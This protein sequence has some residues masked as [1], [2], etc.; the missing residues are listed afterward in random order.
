MTKVL[1]DILG[2]TDGFNEGLK[3]SCKLYTAGQKRKEMMG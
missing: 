3:V 1:K 2:V